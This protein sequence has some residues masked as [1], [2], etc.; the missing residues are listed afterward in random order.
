MAIL[1]LTAWRSAPAAA[2][3][4]LAGVVALGAIAVW[5]GLKAPPEPRLLA[6]AVAEV[7]RLPDNVSAL[8]G[9]RRAVA[10]LAIGAL[11]T[12][13]LWRGRAL[14]MHT[15]GLYA[16]AAIV[17]PLLA[18]ML[19]YLRVTQFD[20]SISFALFAVVLAAVFYLVADRFDNVPRRARTSPLTRLAIGC[21]RRRRRRRA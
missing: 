16:L 2:A 4:A 13:R 3:A 7:L 21:L 19:A 6:P 20:R 8:P 5:P 17:P 9:L 15:A 14:P 12:L 1:A 18:L 11:A 10:T